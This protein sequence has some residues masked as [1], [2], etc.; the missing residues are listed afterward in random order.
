MNKKT[1]YLN[2]FNKNIVF[3]NKIYKVIKISSI[4]VYGLQYTQDKQLILCDDVIFYSFGDKHLYNSFKNELQNKPTKLKISQFYNYRILDDD[5]NIEDIF[6]FNNDIIYNYKDSFFYKNTRELELLY[7]IRY[8]IRSVISSQMKTEQKYNTN[9]K[10]ELLQKLNFVLN[11]YK[12]RHNII[13]EK[14]ILDSLSE[15]TIS[16]LNEPYINYYDEY[17]NIT[18]I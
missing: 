3:D 10:N 12:T 15:Y 5:I 18:V 1:E 6:I 16:F 2:L 14:I 8:L 17:M 4:Y 9:I 13:D 7:N 11:V